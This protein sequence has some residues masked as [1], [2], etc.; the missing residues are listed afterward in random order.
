MAREFVARKGLIVSGSTLASG[1]I[2]ATTYYGDGSNLTG[3]S[4]GGVTINN[5]TNDYLV[6]ATGTANTLN[7]E[8]GLTYNGSILD[9]TGAIRATGDVTAFYSSDERLKENKQVIE[10]PIEKIKQISGYEFDWIPTEG[11][12]TNEGHDIGVIAQE[13]EKVLPEIVATRDNGYKAVRYEKMVAVLI[14]AVKDLQKQIDELKS[15]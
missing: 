9:V 6:T 8:S 2:T 1:S 5:N 11:I 3:I 7:G 10:N 12:H 15:K 14:E 13:V 4:A